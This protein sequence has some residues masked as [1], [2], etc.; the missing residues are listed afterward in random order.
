MASAP[1]AA[2][3]IA[4]GPRPRSLRRLVERLFLGS[5]MVVIAVVVDRRLR[6]V[7]I[8]KI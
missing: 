6:R 3:A 7:F 2:A 4:S 8:R 1:V 5:I